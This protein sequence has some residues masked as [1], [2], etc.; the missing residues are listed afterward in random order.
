MNF[1]KLFFML[2]FVVLFA[3]T[4][5]AQ[6]YSTVYVDV[7]NGS[8][9]YTGEFSTNSP[10]G[11]GPKAT[12]G[13]GL[14]V[15]ANGGTLVIFAGD[16]NGVDNAAGNLNIATGTYAALTTGFTIDLRPLG[17]NTN[18]NLTAGQFIVNLTGAGA[19]LNIV[20]TGSAKLNTTNTT[21][22]LTAGS[23]NLDAATSWVLA[24]GTTLN[25]VGANGFT[26]AA[27][28]KTTNVSL[29]YTGGSSF[30]AG[31]ESN[32]G[33]Y[34]TGTITVNKTAG[35][36]ITFPNAVSTVAGIVL[37]SG[38]A[39]FSGAVV[40]SAGATDVQ[41]NA[42][43]GT[44]TFNGALSL[45]IT[46][47]TA[48]ANLA[49]LQNT[50]TGSIVANSTVTW[51]TPTAVL[52]ANN[53]FVGEYAISNTSTGSILLN[54]NVT[55]SAPA[56]GTAA[57]M[58]IFEAR[59]SS[60][61]VLTIG[62]VSAPSS[63]SNNNYGQLR[64]TG[65]ATAGTINV[66][67][68]TYRLITIN[69]GHTLN[70]TGATTLLDA[71][72]PAAAGVLTNA[73]TINLTGNLTLS[74]ATN[75]TNHLTNG[76]TVTGTAKI[77]ATPG[78]GI[79]HS[80]NG[81][82]LGNLEVN[83][84]A[85]GVVNFI[86]NAFTANTLDLTA[87]TVGLNIG[88][89]TT[90]MNVTGA[91]VTVATTIVQ[92]VTN[93][94]QNGSGSFTLAAGAT[95]TLDV[96][97][98]FSRIAGAFANGGAGNT[99]V[100]F[101]GSGTQSVNGGPL[102][103]VENL[104][105]T[106]AGGIITVGNSIRATAT[107]TISTATNVNFG[108]TNLILN[109]AGNTMIN[110]GAYTVDA[111]SG[112]GV[113]L[114]GTNTVVGGVVG[115]G[116]QL[117]GTGTYSYITVDVGSA[118]GGAVAITGNSVASPTVITTGAAHGLAT[119]DVVYFGTGTANI[120]IGFYAVTVTGATT[121]TIPLNAIADDGAQNYQQMNAA[122]VT[123]TLTG[124]KWNGVLTLRSGA[125]SVATGAL[126]FGPT[127][128]A[129]SIVRY[130]QGT[131]GIQT[132]STA[133]F[134]AANV[135]YDLT[136]TG[137]LAANQPVGGELTN[138]P[139]NVKTWTIQTTGA[140][141][142]NLPSAANVTFAG[143]L[144]VE[145]GATLNLP[146]G[147]ATQFI[148]SGNSKTHTVRGT[149]SFADGGDALSVTGSTVTINGST[150]AAHTATIGNFTT[151]STDLTIANVQS[152]AGTFATTGS[153]VVKLGMGASTLAAADQIITGA[154]TLGGASLTLTT[155]IYGAAGVTLNAGSLNFD[156]FNL[157]I[158]TAGNFTQTAGS[159]T[160]NGGYLVMNRAGATLTLTSALPNLRVLANTTNAAAGEVS[161]ILEIGQTTAATVPPILTLGANALTVSGGT[162]NTLSSGALGAMTAAVTGATPVQITITAHGLTAA[163]DG[164]YVK[165]VGNTEIADGWYPITVTGANTFTIPFNNGAGA[166]AATNGTVTLVPTVVSDNNPA[167]NGGDL[168][169]TG[170]TLTMN[171][172]DLVVEEF[173]LNSTNGLTLAG[174]PTATARTLVIF[175][176][177]TQTAGDINLGIHTLRLT[178]EN[179]AP[180]AYTQTAGSVLATTGWLEFAFTNAASF[181]HQAIGIDRLKIS[182]AATNQT[183]NRQVTINKNLWLF[184][185]AYDNGTGAGSLSLA[186]A[187]GVLITR[188]A[189]NSTLTRTPSFGA[190]VDVTYTG[191]ATVGGGG[192]ATGN[193]LP[194]TT[195]VLRNLTVQ[196]GAGNLIILNANR[197]V[198]GTLKLTSGQIGN[199]TFALTVA[200]GATIDMNGGTFQAAN[201]PTVT[202]YNLTY[203][204]TYNPTSALEFQNGAGIS[205]DLLTVNPGAGNLVQLH[206]ARSVKDLTIT[207]GTLNNGGFN[208]TVLGN[209][210]GAGGAYA[211]AGTLIFNGAVA[212]TLTVPAAGYALGGSLT[213][214]N[215]TGVTLS[216]GN[217]T[218]NAGTTVT[219]T[220]GTLTT[221]ANWIQFA[222][223]AAGQGFTRTGG[224]VNGNVRHA[225]TA[226]AG[227]P[228]VY[229]NG[230]YEFPVG[231]ATMYRPYAITFTSSYPAIN[232]TNIIVGMVDTSPGGSLNLDAGNGLKIAGYPAYYWLVT[233][234]P[235]SFTST[236][237]FD[238]ELTG[239]NIGIPYTSDQNLRIVRRQDGDA[240]YNP[241][242]LQNGST[243]ANYSVITGTDT[244]AVVRTTASI[245]GV[246]TQ[247]TRFSIGVPARVPTF[248][249]SLAAFTVAEGAET[250]N[251]VQLTATPSNSGETITGYTKVSGPAWAVV[252]ATGLVTLTPGFTDFAVAPYPV[253]VRATT[254]L[255]MTADHTL[256]VTV[257]NTN[258]AP[259]F[260]A[261]GAAVQATASVNSGLVHTFTYLAVDADTDALTYTV[262]VD[263]APTGTYSI[264]AALGT[265]TFN[266]V[267]ADAGKTFTFTVTATDPSAATATT[268]TAVTVGYPVAVGDVTGDGTIAADD[269]SEILK[270]V[271]GLVTFTP[272]QMYA[273][274]V[275]ND[276]MVG[277]LDAAWILYRVVNGTWPT[278]KM[279]AAMGSVEI[280]Q[281]QKEAEG[282]LLP[283]NL[284]QTTGV[285]SVYAE[286]DVDANIEVL[287]V[288]GRLPQGWIS[289]SKIENGKVMFAFAGLE[290]LKEGSIA[291]ISLR[292]KDK[293]AN[294]TIFGNANL[295]DGY[296]AALN[297]VT[298]REIPSEFALSQNY[299]NPFNPTTSIKFAIPENANVQLNVYNML[300]QKVRTIMDG[301]QDAGY[302]TV[303][304][305]GTND[306]GSKVSS[307]IYIYR[308]SAGKYNAT[309]KMNLLK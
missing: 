80:F 284:A 254:S 198:N 250:A 256:N 140:F 181:A 192:T 258:R 205:V 5:F 82:G 117:Q 127:G 165:V 187:D 302:Y 136:Y 63:G 291:Y 96:K 110:N 201:A 94:N 87:G 23:V 224:W 270:Y 155:N 225:I 242:S 257:T 175:D 130:P 69:A 48:D 220:S 308:I 178:G 46:D 35:T 33:S 20:S 43:A 58:Y 271:V 281:L 11:R 204:V 231:T 41:N 253:V 196:V 17:G 27:P 128:T 123:T 200:S 246:V 162:I 168:I 52:G 8:D 95:T 19:V 62:S 157:T 32:Y 78:A 85:T 240:V 247:G 261:T 202:N 65:T 276:T 307:G 195:T 215:A 49:S 239:T 236:Q 208:L 266:P 277:A 212:Q 304:W 272:Q 21:V 50:S 77:V 132:I 98:N 206:A 60:T 207:S 221:G 36:T 189:N 152:F 237:L 75:P 104:T 144:Y 113:V 283:I 42:A 31:P 149:I 265:F 197:T 39:T 91:V 278:A 111:G 259:S 234:T 10:A 93:Y 107:V 203:T 182:A 74:S 229:A 295:N 29:S 179:T 25:F 309:M 255:G 26:N 138:S 88:G 158:Q 160:S 235:S 227:S 183:L 306:L 294:A 211:G 252:S 64:L 2:T 142:N 108:T 151:S 290:P 228:T 81:G 14:G 40:V 282:Y 1:K 30:N 172:A 103:Q 71:V 47:G 230:R 4:A 89:T 105:F 118:L 268:T 223:N 199:N 180:I 7:T 176:G 92:T 59:N 262:A 177:L 139:A 37:T 301:M 72:G 125:L 13:G 57:R 279:S 38:N 217:L 173:T 3:T 28:S 274:D 53:D 190:N 66:A 210:N 193:E 264:A 121:F 134:N 112:G 167:T 44:L 222:H 148:L 299:P 16:Y 213:I 24:N 214:N 106:N 97:G 300:G 124:V 216:G 68:G 280:G 115:N 120:P 79:T 209:F 293:E 263:V 147:A 285:L 171:N 101:T 249:A 86:T 275:N 248:G 251:T 243:Y 73:G 34:G 218:M 166:G 186:L 141:L 169:V 219:F 269:A 194:A 18:I 244:T 126:D 99:L 238:V 296:S 150:T 22:T 188:V 288:T 131:S 90:T 12:I 174:V 51:T 164:L 67:G 145:N 305:D 226:G 289:S 6:P 267:F 133:T 83:A 100:S 129:A 55:L 116:F 161:G 292:L 45:G 146:T 70:V 56:N 156:T 191:A 61:G 159:F 241:W 137:V 9:G 15:L 303:N 184:N 260:T 297:S 273:A 54:G 143:T 102:F 154:V 153:A 163:N 233:A 122:K 84:N 170:T 185:G 135:A 114:G 232:P 119:G 298:V 287:G 109:G 245:G 286:L 76:G